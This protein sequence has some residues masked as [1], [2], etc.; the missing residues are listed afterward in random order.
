MHQNQRHMALSVRPSLTGHY[1]VL[2]DK[3]FAIDIENHGLG[4]AIILNWE[5]WSENS[6]SDVLSSMHSSAL[7]EFLASKL[8]SPTLPFVYT[9]KKR[10]TYFP[11]GAVWR[12]FELPASA[13]PDPALL[14]VVKHNVESISLLVEY[15]S[16][17]GESFSETVSKIKK[18]ATQVSTDR[19]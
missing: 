11:A 3:L 12:F 17:Y 5:V 9:S 19:V 15:E 2:T 18:P 13:V 16:I 6:P 7:D 4:P 1:I 14:Q 10:G 8:Q